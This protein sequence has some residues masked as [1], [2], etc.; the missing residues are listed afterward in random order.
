MAM[1]HVAVTA[2]RAAAWKGQTGSRTPSQRLSAFGTRLGL[3]ID[4]ENVR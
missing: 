2:E 3:A 4:V 1:I